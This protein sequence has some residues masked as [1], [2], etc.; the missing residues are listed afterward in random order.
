MV[1]LP[2]HIVDCAKSKTAVSGLFHNDTAFLEQIFLDGGSE[3]G[4]S[5]SINSTPTC[6]SP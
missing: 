5:K 4:Q 3:V 1:Q 2:Q 6:F